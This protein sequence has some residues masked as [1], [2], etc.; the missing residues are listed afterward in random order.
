MK[1]TT[2]GYFKEEGGVALTK[3]PIG[4]AIMRKVAHSARDWG[5]ATGV[6]DAAGNAMN[7]AINSAG[8]A[9]NAARN[10]P[11]NAV[12]AAGNAANAARNAAR[13]AANA[14]RNAPGNAMNAARNAPGNAMNAARNAANAAGNAAGNA[15]NAAKNTNFQPVLNAAERGLDVTDEAATATGL[16]AIGT[17]IAALS[18]STAGFVVAVGGPQVAITLGVVSLVGIAKGSYSNREAA[19][20]KLQPYVWSLIDDEAPKQNIWGSAENLEKAAS[21]AAYL[22]KDAKSQYAQMGS[23]LKQAQEKF[24]S[25]WDSYKLLIEHLIM[26]DRRSG[27]WVYESII[28]RPHGMGNADLGAIGNTFREIH[29]DKV[30]ANAEWDKATKRGGAV[31]EFM[32]RLVHVGNY[33]QCA[34]IIQE[35]TF[36]SLNKGGTV[37]PGDVLYRWEGAQ[38]YRRSL[39]EISDVIEKENANYV[40]AKRFMAQN[41]IR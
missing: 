40:K 31:F 4:G 3:R 26:E 15:V 21:A 19:H 29:N 2:F 33:L 32:R 1:N 12:N 25:F 35:A 8:N 18:G 14:A 24:N 39:K 27:Q 9:A 38:E 34:G 23:K 13:N 28:N 10:A 22:M 37:D 41:N 17:S 30:K 16:V 7:T 5:N 11:G 20:K 6:P 36:A